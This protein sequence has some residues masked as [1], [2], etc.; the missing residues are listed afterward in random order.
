MKTLKALLIMVLAA[1]SL[2]A[3]NK[4]EGGG[5]RATGSSALGTPGSAIGN[6]TN[7][8]DM[9]EQVRGFFATEGFDTQLIR[10]VSG[11]NGVIFNGVVRFDNYNRLIPNQSYINIQVTYVD[12]NNMQQSAVVGIYGSQGMV[13]NYYSY[14]SVQ[15]VFEDQYGTISMS[16]NY[17][18]QYFT[19]EMR[20]TNKYTNSQGTLGQFRIQTCGFFNCGP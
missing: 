12:Q 6:V 1:G 17:D 9:T 3:C 14:A 11:Q 4:N 8:Y 13:T 19:G 5:A 2:V 7:S 10:S 20:Y 16:G 15:I 18:R